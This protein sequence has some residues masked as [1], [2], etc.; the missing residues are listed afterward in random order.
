[1][2]ESYSVEE[3]YRDLARRAELYFEAMIQH[4]N[5]TEGVFLWL[6]DLGATRDREL[7]EPWQESEQRK[8]PADTD[9]FD[10]PL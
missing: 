3:R 10:V 9:G 7:C 4:G 8:F 1:M 2:Q 6:R 5:G